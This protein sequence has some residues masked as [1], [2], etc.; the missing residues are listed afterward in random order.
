MNDQEKDICKIISSRRTIH[1]FVPDKIPDMAVIK[2]AIASA[3]WA[4]NHH[5]TEPWHFFL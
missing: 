2:E 4:P 5:L 1:N 3:R